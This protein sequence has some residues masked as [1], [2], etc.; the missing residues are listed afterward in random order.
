MLSPPK[1]PRPTVMASAYAASVSASSSVPAV[2]KPARSA[3]GLRDRRAG[4]DAREENQ[5]AQRQVDQ[6]DRP[7]AEFGDQNAAER[8]AEVVPIADIVPS[9]PMA[10]PVLS[11]GTVSPT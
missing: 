3:F 9:S 2:S 1:L 4:I 6:E 10:L 11:F 5:D 7:P 8:W